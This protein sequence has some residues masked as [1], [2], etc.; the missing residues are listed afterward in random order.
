VV[1]VESELNVPAATKYTC[2]I[3]PCSTLRSVDGILEP[4][5]RSLEQNVHQDERV[6][7]GRP[8]HMDNVDVLPPIITSTE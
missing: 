3:S 1:S 5:C 4:P 8:M 7:R 2:S 6:F